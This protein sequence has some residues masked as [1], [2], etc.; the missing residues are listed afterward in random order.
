MQQGKYYEVLMN[1]NEYKTMWWKDCKRGVTSIANKQ[2][3]MTKCVYVS[4]NAYKQGGWWWIIN[5]VIS[6]Y[7]MRAKF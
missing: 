7:K 3:G 6:S 5:N 1:L 4:L 2:K